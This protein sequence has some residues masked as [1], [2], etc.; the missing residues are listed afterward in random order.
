MPN[1]NTESLYDNWEEVWEDLTE[2]IFNDYNIPLKEWWTN[3]YPGGSNWEDTKAYIEKHFSFDDGTPQVGTEGADFLS[4]LE[5]VQKVADEWRLEKQVTPIPTKPIENWWDDPIGFALQSPEE[6]MEIF[7]E[8]SYTTSENPNN[9]R[10]MDD[11]DGQTWRLIRPYVL[12]ED[13]EHIFKPGDWFSAGWFSDDWSAL[14]GVSYGGGGIDKYGPPSKLKEG[15][16]IFYV[17]NGD[18]GYEIVEGNISNVPDGATHFAESGGQPRQIDELFPKSEEEPAPGA[19]HFL[20]PKPKGIPHPM[21]E[22]GEWFGASGDPEYD[23]VEGNISNVPDGATHVWDAT[24]GDTGDWVPVVLDKDGMLDLPKE[25]LQEVTELEQF[26]E[27]QRQNE[28]LNKQWQQQFEYSKKQEAA[29]LGWEREKWYSDQAAARK[30][31]EDAL[32]TASFNAV[33]GSIG[34]PNISTGEPRLAGAGQPGFTGTGPVTNFL[35]A[36]PPGTVRKPGVINTFKSAIEA[37]YEPPPSFVTDWLEKQ[38]TP[39]PPVRGLSDI[40]TVAP[41]AEEAI[42]DG[43]QKF[44]TEETAKAQ[45]WKMDSSGLP[46]QIDEYDNEMEYDW[47]SLDPYRLWS[48]WQIAEANRQQAR[49]EGARLAAQTEQQGGATWATYPGGLQSPL[50]AGIPT[51]RDM[52]NYF[53]GTRATTGDWVPLTEEEFQKL[54]DPE[55]VAIGWVPGSGLSKEL[56]PIV[57]EFGNVIREGY[58]S[59]DDLQRH[60]DHDPDADAYMR[61]LEENMSMFDPANDPNV[62]RAQRLERLYAQGPKTPESFRGVVMGPSRE[63]IKMSTLGQ[64]GNVVR[65]VSE[66]QFSN[67]T[68]RQQADYTGLVSAQKGADPGSYFSNIGRMSR[69]SRPGQRARRRSVFV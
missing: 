25:D 50:G 22:G 4:I 10:F 46:V 21:G 56:S 69:A 30:L 47:T 7:N 53:Q 24:T 3:Q 16:V 43:F 11:P 45:G 33:L 23:I 61:T 17:P 15:E 68:P 35:P 29:R 40:T 52:G 51:L 62:A 60:R 28:A 26:T 1:K 13:N 5:L 48:A 54:A 9:I 20:V 49:S 2:E 18:G 31:S 12:D 37:G 57:D 14:E 44:I 32:R 65:P 19:M 39:I 63:H 59:I 27:L 58:K 36:P 8:E 55:K 67:F 38:V 6:W 41:S 64:F 42:Q 34:R 66:A